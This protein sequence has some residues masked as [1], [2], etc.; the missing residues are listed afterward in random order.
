MTYNGPHMLNFLQ[1][2]DIALMTT[3]ISIIILTPGHL[4]SFRS[5]RRLE[6]LTDKEGGF[7]ELMETHNS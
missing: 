7:S 4:S 1:S 5:Q 3:R 2:W 6:I